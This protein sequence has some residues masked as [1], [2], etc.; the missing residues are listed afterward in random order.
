MPENAPTPPPAAPPANP[1]SVDPFAADL[2]KSMNLVI[3]GGNVAP[4]EPAKLETP[5]PTV[6]PAMVTL[7]E[8]VA[9][10]PEGAP[11][12]P[13]PPAPTPQPAPAPTPT[14]VPEPSKKVVVKKAE[15][16]P[17]VV[18]PAP[19]PAP[20][21]QPPA[22]PP[23]APAPAPVNSDEEYIKGLSEAQREELELAR[24][25][26]SKH[27][28]MKGKA[29]EVLAYFKKVDEF[30]LKHPD[31]T[32]ESDE[33]KQF[34]ANN[35]PKFSNRR[36]LE[37]SRIK[38]QAVDEAAQ[39]L[40]KETDDKLAEIR[41]KTYELET[42]P[43]V[44]KAVKEFEEALT[45]GQYAVPE[46]VSDIGNEVAKRIK[47]VGYDKALKEYPVEAP[48]IK[49]SM[50]AAQEY[51]NIMNGLATVDFNNPTHSWLADFVE[52]QGNFFAQNAK[53]A[54][55]V[56]D[57]RTFLPRAQ[58]SELARTNPKEATRHWTFTDAQILEMIAVNGLVAAH[59]EVQRLEQ[60]GFKRERKSAKPENQLP[61]PAPQPTP[62][63]SLP[64]GSPRAGASSIPPANS[65]PALT[66]SAKFLD[67]LVPGASKLVS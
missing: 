10:K 31:L 50:A 3:E 64:T 60:A 35:Q 20:A 23:P 6:E 43:K 53:P 37:V 59:S 40:R 14:S 41:R 49:Q 51:L 2:A 27:P 47:E 52:Q 32:P 42:R 61:T 9:M 65:A 22:T 66:E 16:K 39:K 38:D 15:P 36:A 58:F 56:V 62:Q 67:A 19:T 54:Q 5:P 34:V 28:E 8:K 48:L 17:V 57:G 18:P 1:P 26:E 24:Y 13:P 4:I 25:A 7:G 21:P 45:S 30:A 44:E 11:N 29:N 33:F 46:G 55:K 12:T 63:P